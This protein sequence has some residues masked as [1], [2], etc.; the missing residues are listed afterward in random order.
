MQQESQLNTAHKANYFI[1][2]RPIEPRKTRA[3]EAGEE[4]H[5][6]PSLQHNGVM[7]GNTMFHQNTKRKG[8]CVCV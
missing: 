6:R 1:C 7:I 3:V 8:W 2:A 4:V 5:G